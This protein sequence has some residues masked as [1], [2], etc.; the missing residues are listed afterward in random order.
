MPGIFSRPN[1]TIYFRIR[2]AVTR[3]QGVPAALY[4]SSGLSLCSLYSNCVL[5]G[6]THCSSSH[7]LNTKPMATV[8]HS[9]AVLGDVYVDGL[10]SGCGVLDFTKPAVVY[11]KDK[12]LNGC[13]RG[14]VN[15]RRQQPLSGPLSFGSSTFDVN[16]RIRDSS[17]LHGSWLKNFCTSSSACPSAGASRS[18][19]FDGGPPDEQLS[20]T[21]FSPDLYVIMFFFFI[22]NY[23][24]PRIAFK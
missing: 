2:E 11:F 24:S 23:V 17:L 1:A 12:T 13:R 16:W 7:T 14:S 19:S 18:V 22:L 5:P 4:R 21:P 20:N 10:V 8:S 9:N 6:S 15:L 3:Q